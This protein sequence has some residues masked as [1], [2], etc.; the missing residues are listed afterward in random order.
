MVGMETVKNIKMYSKSY[1][2]CKSDKMWKT[3]R[4]LNR[5]ERTCEAAVRHVFPGGA[6]KVPHTIFDLL[7][8]EDIEIPEDLKYFPY[9]ATFDFECYFK[10]ETS[11]IYVGSGTYPTECLCLFKLPWVQPTKMLRLHW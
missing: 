9:C 4:A 5:Q 11:K 7:V 1:C 6:Y 10:G 8:D 3:T 2:C